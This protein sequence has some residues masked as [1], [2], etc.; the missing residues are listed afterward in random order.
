MIH[1]IS[2]LRRAQVTDQRRDRDVEDR[3]VHHDDQQAEAQ[4]AEDQPAAGVDG[5]VEWIELG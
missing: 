2:L 1:W 4:H 3:V 5:R